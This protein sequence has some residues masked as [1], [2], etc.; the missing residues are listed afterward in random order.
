MPAS[1]TRIGAIARAEDPDRFL[2]ALFAPAA[3][4]EALFALIAYNHELARARAVARTPLIALMRLQWWRDVVREATEGMPPRRH[5]VAEPLHAAIAGGALHPAALLAM[6]DAR[7][8]EAEDEGI[9]TRSAFAAYLRGTA[10]G[11]ALAAGRLLG[12]TEPPLLAGLEAAG[13]LYGLGGVLRS[14]PALARQG[15]CLLPA[16]A[17]AEQGLRA[18]DVVA[19]PDSPALHRVLRTIA[20][21]GARDVAAAAEVLR[22]LSGAALPAALPLVLA[23]RDLRRLAA[24]GRPPP[25]TAPRPPSDRLA[26][27]AAWLRRRV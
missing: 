2:C 22:G 23:R 25:A 21:Q 3:Q 17:M 1:L 5:E 15:R 9:P 14:V 10:G 7:E 8:T 24:T 11:F 6:A 13:T 26:V 12:V 27:T 16:E 18:E 4:R 20:A 19:A